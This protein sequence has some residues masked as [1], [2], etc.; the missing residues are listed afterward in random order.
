M[1]ISTAYSLLMLRCFLAIPLVLLGVFSF[2]SCGDD[3]EA[4]VQYVTEYDTITVT[5]IDTVL[6]TEVTTDTIFQTVA[7][8]V[9][10]TITD[11]LLLTE[12]DTFY[13]VAGGGLTSLICIRHAE[14]ADNTSDADLSEE[15]FERADRLRDM[16]HELPLTAIYSTAYQR[17]LKTAAPTAEDHGLEVQEYDPD[18][19]PQVL[20]DIMEAEEGGYVFIVGHAETVPEMVNTALGSEVIMEIDESDHSNMYILAVRE[21]G[22]SY[23]S[24]L[25]Y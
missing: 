11:T 10:L 22:W 23:L 24:H 1:A 25:I 4:E 7:D 13:V 12:T 15:G 9:F 20:H 19:I 17:A 8:T 18:D 16:L 14:K 2:F 5:R 6:L 21:I 3:T